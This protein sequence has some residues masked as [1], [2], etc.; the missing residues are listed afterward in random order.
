MLQCNSQKSRR[1]PNHEASPGHKAGAARVGN[2][3]LTA[4]RIIGLA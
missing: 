3:M 1:G 4:R 2:G